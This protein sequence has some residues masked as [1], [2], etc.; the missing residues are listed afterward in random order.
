VQPAIT[1]KP[2]ADAFNVSKLYAYNISNFCARIVGAQ[3]A[4]VMGKA[5]KDINAI[6]LQLHINQKLTLLT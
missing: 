3:L 5:H 1:Y 6:S 2:K 4:G